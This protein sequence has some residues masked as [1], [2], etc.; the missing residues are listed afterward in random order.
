[1][2][3]G[4][5]LAPAGVPVHLRFDESVPEQFIEQVRQ[6]WASMRPQAAPASDNMDVPASVLVT[7]DD[8][9]KARARWG[10]AE[11]VVVDASQPV[12]AH[13]RL[14]VEVTLKVLMALAGQQSLFHAAALGDP[15]SHQAMI[16]VGPSGRGK[17]T[18]AR[19]LG[20]HFSYLSDETAIVEQSGRIRPYP[21]PLSIIEE[22]GTPKAQ[23]D[24]TDLG[25]N[26]VA[27]DDFGYTLRHVV[28][29][30]RQSEGEPAEPQLE[31]VGIV[32]ALIELVPQ[33][34]GLA[35]TEAGV[36]KLIALVDSCGGAFRLRYTEIADT[37]PLMRALLAGELAPP[38]ERSEVQCFPETPAGDVS[39][40]ARQGPD[41]QAWVSRMPGTSG[42]LAEERMLL[43]HDSKLVEV[44]PFAADCWLALE[45]PRPVAQLKAE[46]EASYGEIPDDAF[47]DVIEQLRM[48]QVL[49]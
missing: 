40:S 12:A 20:R 11:L 44:S 31:R 23:H 39:S 27:P 30:D 28:L 4:L 13:E 8:A 25:L 17:T 37:L 32:D 14:T 3:R 41:G 26:A 47:A 35:R 22:R 6:A 46:L 19:F 29:L 9:A 18:A 45:T 33:T 5:D 15:R 24:P 38:A 7:A 49:A 10:E 21:K 2:L 36:E 1:M 16:L 42:Y 48:H 34:S 43:L